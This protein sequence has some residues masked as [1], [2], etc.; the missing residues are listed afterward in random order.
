[1]V[2]D[3]ILLTMTIFY[4]IIVGFSYYILINAKHKIT[5]TA[6]YCSCTSILLVLNYSC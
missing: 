1:M 6:N 4:F 5:I 2:E 3:C